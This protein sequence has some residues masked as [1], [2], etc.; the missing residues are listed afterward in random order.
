[1]CLQLKNIVFHNRIERMDCNQL[2]FCE[3]ESFQFLVTWFL[4]LLVFFCYDSCQLL[5]IWKQPLWSFRLGDVGG[6]HTATEEALYLTKYADHVHVLVQRDKL[7]ASKAMQDRYGIGTCVF[8]AVFIA[9]LSRF[10]VTFLLF[11]FFNLLTTY[12]LFFTDSNDITLSFIRM[13]DFSRYHQLN[14]WEGFKHISSFKN[15]M[16]FNVVWAV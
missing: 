14:F 13:I 12:V 15:V 9:V 5:Q 7:R 2:K 6:G 10:C 3:N 1:M 16:T 4:F 11:R 8:T